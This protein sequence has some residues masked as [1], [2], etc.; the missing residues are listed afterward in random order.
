M[1]TIKIN[2]QSV[3]VPEG[4]TILEAARSA[5]IHIPTLCYLKGYTTGGRCRMCLVE[6]KGA[7]TPMTAC[8]TKVR[9]G[10]EVLTETERVRTRRRQNLE[11]IAS[12]HRMDCTYCSRFPYC[13]LNALMREYGLDDRT[14]RYCREP[15]YDTS[16]LHLVRDNSKCILCGRCVAACQKQGANAIGLTNRGGKARVT[17]GADCVPMS[18]TGCI[19]CGQCILACPVGALREKDDTQGVLNELHHR[20]KRVW[21]GVTPEAAVLLGECMREEPGTSPVGKTVTLLKKLGFDKVFPLDMV[22]KAAAKQENEE[23]EQRLREQKDLPMISSRCPGMESF[24]RKI[25]PELSPLLSKCG[26][27]MRY[28][29]HYCREVETQKNGLQPEDVYLVL[30]SSCTADKNADYPGADACLTVREVSAMFR[31]SCV[32]DFTAMQVWRS[33]EEQPFDRPADEALLEAPDPVVRL[34][35][36]ASC[37]RVSSLAALKP[38]VEQLKKQLKEPVQGRLYDYL[39]CRACEDGCV[40]GGGSPRMTAQEMEEGTYLNKRREALER[41]VHR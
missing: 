34:N 30:I 36:L 31:K 28:F 16:A 40:V 14:Y 1:V 15:E 24:I 11:L 17:P 8:S 13:E 38:L 7:R 21:A 3:Q 12:N 39:D 5:D 35:E 29:A 9:E 18:K 10:M 6:V 2:G 4:S 33:L 25:Y 23:L 27:R 37:V 26:N 41:I 19:G 20:K 22:D 32:S